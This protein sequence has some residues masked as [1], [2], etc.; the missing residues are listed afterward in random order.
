[1]G[2]KGSGLIGAETMNNKI[3]KITPNLW[4]NTEAEEAAKFY[5]SIFK[6]SEISHIIRYG[7]ERHEISGKSEGSVMTVE[8]R[9]EGQK[10]VL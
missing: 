2:D 10:F 8:F 5:T 4:F 3:Q 7:K 6:N 9:L 1:M